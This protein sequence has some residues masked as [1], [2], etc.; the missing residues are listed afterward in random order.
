MHFN[1]TMITNNL[2]RH[3]LFTL[4]AGQIN[5]LYVFETTK[6][7]VES[8]HRRFDLFELHTNEETFY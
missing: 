2:V 6:S 3:P 8:A 1:E 7:N 4:Q 5:D